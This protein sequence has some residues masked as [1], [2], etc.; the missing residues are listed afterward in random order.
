VICG[1]G[2]DIVQISRLQKSLDRYGDRFAQ[3]I[4]SDSEFEEYL[5]QRQKAHLLAKRFAAKEAAVKA[6]GTGF[7][8]GI[9]LRHIIVTHNADGQ[10]QLCFEAVAKNRIQSM[11]VIGSHLSIADEKEYAVA[12]VVLEK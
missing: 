2:T 9:C 8:Q 11:G 10:P 5:Q 1:V 12:F 4:L 7:T 3:R 6:L